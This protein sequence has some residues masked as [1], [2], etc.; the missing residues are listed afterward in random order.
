MSI[1][2]DGT[3][4][5]SFVVDNTMIVLLTKNGSFKDIADAEAIL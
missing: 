3:I 2:Q 4:K 5:V 1:S